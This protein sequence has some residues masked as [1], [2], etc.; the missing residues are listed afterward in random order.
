MK[1]LTVKGE[2]LLFLRFLANFPFKEET[3]ILSRIFRI[4]VQGFVYNYLLVYLVLG[5]APLLPN[6]V[7][8]I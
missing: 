2:C 1:D 5:P 7:Y 3:C 6:P 4:L 8:V